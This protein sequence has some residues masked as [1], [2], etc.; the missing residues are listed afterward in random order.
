MKPLSEK[1]G[2]GNVWGSQVMNVLKEESVPV[3]PTPTPSITP[4]Q[5]ITPTPTLTPTPTPTPI[6]V[7]T[8]ELVS[9]ATSTTIASTY[10]FNTQSIGD[11]GGA[12]C[13][14]IVGNGTDGGLAAISSS[15]NGVA[16]PTYGKFGNQV[17]GICPSVGLIWLNVTGT[18]TAN[19]SITFNG[20]MEVCKIYTYRIKNVNSTDPL[21]LGE[22]VSSGSSSIQINNGSQPGDSL[23]VIVAAAVDLSP[24][25]PTLSFTN[26]T[27]ED[28]YNTGFGTIGAV[29]TFDETAAGT[30]TMDFNSNETT[31]LVAINLVYN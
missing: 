21:V 12:I 1:V 30:L 8:I 6:P 10:T 22:A 9:S 27:L 5:T 13:V 29:G 23:G 15:I 14:A 17:G 16:A 4:T 31:G 25:I 24:P 28:I 20:N 11:G 26:A 2:K 19:I 3:S 7:P 18:S